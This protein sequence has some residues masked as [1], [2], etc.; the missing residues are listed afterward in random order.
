[1]SKATAT[2][3]GEGIIVKGAM[4]P[5]YERVLTPGAMA[6]V[7]TLERKYGERRRELL[8]ARAE[9]QKRF[10]AGERPDFL[11]ETRAVREDDS[12]RVAPAPADLQDR[13]VEITGPTDRR[14]VIN[15]LNSGARVF[16]ADFED[17]NTP[18]WENMVDGQ[19][20]LKD[21][22]R[23]EIRFEREDGR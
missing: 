7:A 3:I 1:M 4:K 18:T 23:R 6:F 20:N 21:A 19:V 13:R 10:D 12:W 16:M 5:G 15:A 9:R 2:T 22:I 11:P 17:A 14:M 8:A